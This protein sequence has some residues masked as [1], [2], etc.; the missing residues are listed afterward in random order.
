[1]RSVGL[2]GKLTTLPEFDDQAE[3]FNVFAEAVVT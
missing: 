2:P 1:M 3:N